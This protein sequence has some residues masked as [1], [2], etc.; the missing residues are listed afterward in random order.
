[1]PKYNPK[2]NDDAKAAGF[3]DWT[4][5]FANYYQKWHDDGDR[6]CGGARG[7]DAGERMSWRSRPT[8]QQRVFK[9]NP[10][11]F[12]VDSMGQQL[13]YIDRVHERFLNAD[14]QT[15]AIL[16]G[17]IDYKAQ[18]NELQSYP[19]LKENEA[20]GKYTVLLPAGSIG[21]SLA[22]NITHADPKLRAVYSDLRFRQAVS[23]AINREEMNQVLYFGLGEISQA[24]PAN[25]PSFTD[26]SRRRLHDRIR[27]S[28]R[29]R[30][31]STRWG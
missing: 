27:S 7:A 28:T 18:G 30:L 9:A 23:H 21:S 19:T 14:L 16:N 11:Y 1:M 25:T 31:C 4:K 29:R 8:P 20:K 13:P 2:A 5:W 17:E 10:Y 3:D 12:K 24:L 6:D 22:F 15:L 26:R